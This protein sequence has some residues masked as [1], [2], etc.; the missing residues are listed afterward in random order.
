MAVPLTSDRHFP[1]NAATSC[2]Q[3]FEIAADAAPTMESEFPLNAAADTPERQ[4]GPPLSTP[5]LA[6]PPLSTPPLA[7]PPL[8]TPPLATPY[9]FSEVSIY[10]CVYRVVMLC[11]MLSYWL[12]NW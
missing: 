1:Q 10:T 6:T 7:T 5:P 8:S 2:N 9:S 3:S 11:H 4:Q 12:V